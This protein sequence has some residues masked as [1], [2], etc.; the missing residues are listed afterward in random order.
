MK[1][2][3]GFAAAVLTLLL[4]SACGGDSKDDGDGRTGGGGSGTGGASATGGART[5]GT[6]TGG[7]ESGGEEAGGADSGGTV[8]GGAATGGAAT[9]GE[10]A[11]GEA[12][13]GAEA[14]GG[15]A[16]SVEVGGEATGGAATGGAATGG[17]E[18]GGADAGDA[19]A[20]TGG[21]VS[22][23]GAGGEGAV[24][25][26]A[27]S[28]QGGAGATATGGAAG[29]PVT[30]DIGDCETFT[31]CGGDVEGTW[32]YTA[33]CFDPASLGMD[34]ETLALLTAICP[35]ATYETTFEVTGTVS[36]S[37]GAVLRDGGWSAEF[38][39]VMPASCLTLL[40]SCTNLQT[41]IEA[42]APE[43][44]VAC[45]D[46]VES[47]DCQV[48]RGEE[49]WEATSYTV[50]GNVLTLSDGRTFD[51]CVSGSALEY[52]ETSEDPEPG[53]FQLALQ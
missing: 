7:V 30:I 4:G 28:G 50:D 1:A 2:K 19:G 47:C 48:S 52:V 35:T 27:G 39:L 16:G 42:A 31:P 18:A 33:G 9:G 36:F 45:V 46:N 12:A 26:V 5:G 43:A 38:D 34:E 53:T 11:G 14:V 24:G 41:T 23:A 20:A 17:E 13:G 10:E 49:G 21:A 3:I 29:A 25:G 37:D 8:T 32:A 44:T 22:A 40:G 51:Y 15:E 6:G